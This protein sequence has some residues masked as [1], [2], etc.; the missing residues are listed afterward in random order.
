MTKNGNGEGSI[1]EHKRNGKISRLSRILHGLYSERPQT[2]L[3]AGQD[4]G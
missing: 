2:S 4:Q 1:D 3:R